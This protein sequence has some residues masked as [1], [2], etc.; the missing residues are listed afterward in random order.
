MNPTQG[1]WLQQVWLEFLMMKTRLMI[2]WRLVLYCPPWAY[3]FEIPVNPHITFADCCT[4][5]KQTVGTLQ[6]YHLHYNVAIVSIKGFRC[7]RTEEFHDPGQIKRK[8]VLSVGRVFKSGKLM[9]TSG[10]LSEKGSNLDC[11]ELM[12]STCKVTKVHC[13]FRYGGK[14]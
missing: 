14:K 5:S 6:H 4:P 8:E 1:S 13:W 11:K 9:A 12:I 7:L 3:S 10:I 2:T